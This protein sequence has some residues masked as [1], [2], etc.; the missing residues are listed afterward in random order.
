M[1]AHG[2]ASA[3]CAGVPGRDRLVLALGEHVIPIPETNRLRYLEE[4]V[5]AAG[6]EL[7]P[8]DLAE[9]DALPAAV[10]PPLLTARRRAG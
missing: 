8:E 10:V 6:L 4:N 9:L 5:A 1:A 2:T 3:W 7:A